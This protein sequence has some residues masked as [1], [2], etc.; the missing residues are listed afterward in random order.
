MNTTSAELTTAIPEKVQ[1]IDAKIAKIN[2]F[3]KQ[4]QSIRKLKVRREIVDDIVN[5]LQNKV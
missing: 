3:I 2:D 5:K 4:V 1:Y